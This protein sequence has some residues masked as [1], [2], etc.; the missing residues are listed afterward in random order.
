MTATPRE[1]ALENLEAAGEARDA[2]SEKLAGRGRM[3][4]STIVEAG[5]AVLVVLVPTA[6]ALV[7]AVLDVAD[8][9]REAATPPPPD[10][11]APRFLAD[12]WP[13]RMAEW[14]VGPEPDAVC[15]SRFT[16]PY[17]VRHRCKLGVG[18]VDDLHLDGAA[19]WRTE[20][21]DDEVPPLVAGVW[22]SHGYA[23]DG[24]TPTPFASEVE[25]SRHALD[26]HQRV[27]FVPFGSEVPR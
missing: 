20:E 6:R 10:V 7:W 17:D 3:D 19:S 13:A 15:P 14:G 25:A 16:D 4:L 8:A 27:S 21:Q 24:G 1:G 22:V 12:P 5:V 2:L 23:T 9:V 18:H 26:L 11:R